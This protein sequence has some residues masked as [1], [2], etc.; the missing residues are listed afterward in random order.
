MHSSRHSS[1][2]AR[3]V[4]SIGR[5]VSDM[6]KTVSVQ[7]H[8]RSPSATRVE[9]ETGTWKPPCVYRRRARI[10]A[11]MTRASLARSL[12]LFSE[13][14]RRA[15]PPP[16]T[17]TTALIEP[18][19]Q[20][21]PIVSCLAVGSTSSSSV[22]CSCTPPEPPTSPPAMLPRAAFRAL[23]TR[24]GLAA[25][26]TA[27]LPSTA[28]W[29]RAYAKVGKPRTNPVLADEQDKTRPSPVINAA[30]QPEFTETAS[31]PAA[32]TA[33]TTST[34]TTRPRPASANATVN[35]AAEQA[36]GTAEE[37]AGPKSPAANTEPT[38]ESPDA[39]PQ[40]P[41]EPQKPL[42]DLRFGIPSTFAAEHEAEGNAKRDP[43]DP[44]ASDGP[45]PA[46]GG[47][48]G[49]ELPKSAYE[50]S[51]DRRRNRVANWGYLASLLFGTVGAAYMG[52]PWETDEEAK[53]HPDIANGWT[54]ALM[55]ARAAARVNG[56]KAYYTEP[57][58]QKLLPDK[59]K[60]PGGAPELT[61]VLSLEDLLL[62][63]EWSTKHG[64]RLAKR[65]GL[66]Y[67]LRYLSSQ[68][69]L[70]I[71]TS[72]KS[73]DADPIIRKLDPFRLVMWPLFR[74]A[75]RFENG[76]YIKDLSYLNRDPSKVII[77][78]T[79]KS[80][81]QLQPEN[82][83]ILP[84]WKGEPGDKGLVAMIPFLE[85][86]A[87]MSQTGQPLDVRQ[88][89]KSMEG[90]DI[91]TEY[92]RREAKLREA[93]QRDLAEQKKKSRGSAGGMFMKSLGLDAAKS[94]GMQLGDQNISQ[95]MSEGK[96]MIDMYRDFNIQNYQHLDKQIRENGDQ[97]LK[98]MADEEKKMQEAAMKDMKAG[99]FSWLGAAP[100]SATV[101]S[102]A[103]A[104][105]AVT[106]HA[107][108]PP[109]ETK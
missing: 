89:L 74:E 44:N 90:K 68:Y 37:L 72:V 100:Q 101:P 32:N 11:A 87:M 26:R 105:E 3:A 99:A 102:A 31:A 109:T 7:R 16:P 23:R 69:E 106:A 24:P 57:T 96:M 17:T 52:R 10:T 39:P 103:S 42:P 56:Q 77:I 93:F 21:C 27:A 50:T 12:C 34:P 83:I 82:A 5:A 76:E 30:Q 43:N 18:I 64:Y 38:T 4:R 25:P 104:P 55:Y 46:F 94:P 22:V 28:Q 20:H 53:A 95:G 54:P 36:H 1:G 58:F 41:Q 62:H 75:T 86:L 59:D 63:S 29:T 35:Q 108:V 81:V 6:P 47:A 66:D 84:K 15:S 73:M 61:L 91:P 107:G 13:S 97:W 48:G 98:E 78:D 9:T 14:R 70:V 45:E 65:P 19:A 79:D 8:G 2:W 88:V 67:F 92:A 60:I 71:F 80:H 49:R 40:E 85:Y 33:P 51:T